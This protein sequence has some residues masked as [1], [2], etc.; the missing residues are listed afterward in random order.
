C[1]MAGSPRVSSE[2]QP[3][4]CANPRYLAGN[5]QA[6][7][8]KPCA[9]PE[10]KIIRIKVPPQKVVVETP[11]KQAHAAPEAALNAPQEVLLVPRTVFMPYVA[12]T[13]TGPARVLSLQGAVPLTAPPPPPAPLS[14]P[15]PK[16]A[17]PPLEKEKPCEAAPPCRIEI[18][19][20]CSP[21]DVEAI[22]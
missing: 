9:P 11:P 17:A 6:C 14:A 8:P 2:A 22:H 12:Q 3:L 4:P 20:T 16:T 10:T 13:P 19:D 15:P 7:P 1:E 18:P 5:S 21:A